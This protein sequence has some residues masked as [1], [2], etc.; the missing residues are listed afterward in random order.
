MAKKYQLTYRKE[1]KR[2]RWQKKYGGKTYYFPCEAELTKEESYAAALEWWKQKRAEI[3][4]AENATSDEDARQRH[5]DRLEYL[6]GE[7]INATP[8]AEAAEKAREAFHLYMRYG[9][10]SSITNDWH[11]TEFVGPHLTSHL[12]AESLATQEKELP[13][14]VDS[15]LRSKSSL[16]SST[17]SKLRTN[18]DRF[19]N[20]LGPDKLASAIT[21]ASLQEYKQFLESLIA[22]NK[23]GSLTA[24]DALV[25]L[26]S[27]VTWCH[28]IEAIDTLPRIMKPRKLTIATATKEV[29]PMPVNEVKTMLIHA[30]ERTRLFI[31]LMINCGMYP[32]DIGQL[33]QEQVDWTDGI[34]SRK[35]T[36]TH[37][38]ANVPIVRYKL[39]TETFD[40]LKLYRSK[41]IRFALLNKKSKPLWSRTGNDRNDDIGQAY[42]RFRK[43]LAKAKDGTQP[44]LGHPKP[45][46]TLRKTSASL[47][48]NSEYSQYTEYFLGHSAAKHIGAVANKHYI[49]VFDKGFFAALS[50][51][52]KQY[53]IV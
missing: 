3:D 17:R 14:L 50:W 23:L 1:G 31:L 15:F 2:R 32:S 39:W 37:S 8:G 24:R 22:D 18:L 40:L 4:S 5:V 25:N 12:L 29:Q 44:I 27:F 30:T 45:L 21:S 28:E 46:S 10:H 38:H 20:W 43:S 41:D 42:D 13:I 36:K 11:I 26:K 7:L 51:L 53:E 33:T 52:G 49:R 6:V 16:Q 47:L 35:R 48:F 19:L 9:N 34:I